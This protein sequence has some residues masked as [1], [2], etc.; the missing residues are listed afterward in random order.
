MM[1]TIV[2]VNVRLA[3]LTRCF[4]LFSC[5]MLCF[6]DLPAQWKQSNGPYGGYIYSL[7]VSGQYLFAGTHGSG[8]FRSSDN[9]VTW[10]SASAGLTSPHVYD[11]LSSGPNLFAACPGGGGVCVSTDNGMSWTPR[12]NGLY[13][14]YDKEVYSLAQIDTT[15]FAGTEL[16][17]GVFRSTDYGM[18]WS[19]AN[20][21][22]GS[23]SVWVLAVQ[24]THLIAGTYGGG[25]YLSTD[26]GSSW[27]EADS[28]ITNKY[29]EEFAVNDS[30]IFAGTF[31]AGVFRSTD[32]CRHWTQVINGLNDLYIRGFQV[33]GQNVYVANDLGVSVTTDNGAHWTP[34]SSGLTNVQVRSLALKGGWLFAGTNG[35]GLFG[36]TNGGTGWAMLN[37][38][39]S[40]TSVVSFASIGTN[41]FA[42]TDGTGAFLSTDNG[43]HWTPID[44]GLT[45][46]NIRGLVS[47]GTNLFA[48]TYG[49]VFVSTD[50][51]TS[52]SNITAGM[53][54]TFVLCVA[55]HGSNLFAGTSGGVLM[56]TD[57]GAHWS[58]M[59]SG[60]TNPNVYALYV[61]G[62]YIF[63]GTSGG[64]VFRSSDDGANWT[65][66]INGLTNNAVFTLAA[67]PDSSGD[68][69]LFAGTFGSGV[70]RTTDKGDNWTQVTN[71]LGLNFVGALAVSGSNLFAGGP[72]NGI[73]LTTDF[74]AT[75]S[76]VNN[77]LRS[78]SVNALAIGPNA[79]LPSN[80]IAGTAYGS[81][82]QR[83]LSQMIPSKIGYSMV[84]GW[85]LVSVPLAVSDFSVSALFPTAIS[86]CF[87]YEGTYVLKDTLLNG[88][89]YWVKF[90][91][92]QKI[93]LA[94]DSILIDSINVAAGWNL[95]GALSES[96]AVSNITS[97]PPGMVTSRFFGYFDGYY[98]T[99]NLVPG[100]GYWVKVDTDGYLILNSH[101][102]SGS[103]HRIRI[104]STDELPP[105]P[106]ERGVR[107][108]SD[109]PRRFS[110]Q[111][112]YPNPFNPSA[113]IEYSLP[114]TSWITL[115]VYNSIGQHVAVLQNALQDAGYKRVHWDAS[116]FPSGIYFY[117]LHATVRSNPANTFTQTM[118]A[119]LLK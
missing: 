34:V 2:H 38:G 104:V 67:L 111:Q 119:V 42:G 79:S 5:I 33:E 21:G 109:V 70:F 83:P 103:S 50:G 60:L 49:G 62:S 36:S 35:G 74:G 85:N 32:S 105:A 69:D 93:P 65:Q 86:G 97:S 110:L 101:L 95:I 54:Y 40:N 71:G 64:G 115:D 53:T 28:G 89:G 13:S 81:A 22:L 19:P 88:T 116:G 63:A 52:W 37:N 11:F 118:K 75:W 57:N 39:L 76:A 98:V 108:V 23:T 1:T 58:L 102:S 73:Y 30:G 59:N 112:A 9:G 15:I 7:G 8:A 47:M 56:T 77:G 14:G 68:T 92:D 114:V 100:Y 99:D 72:V 48:G 117:T 12:N 78:T 16:G 80:L 96:V 82:W 66:V 94:G 113:V 84:K 20:A 29:V 43:V 24:G 25:A 107:A 51:G 31:G 61:S 90:D 41:L 44:S 18:T 27:T 91:S 87:A 6:A 4:F 26:D 55:V 10:T 17:S 45:Q 3:S 46:N 106:P